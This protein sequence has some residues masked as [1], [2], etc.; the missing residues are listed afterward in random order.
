MWNPLRMLYI[1]K[2]LP[3]G[4]YTKTW[5]DTVHFQSYKNFKHNFCMTKILPIYGDLFKST[6]DYLIRKWTCFRRLRILL[7]FTTYT[8]CWGLNDYFDELLTE[9]Q[10]RG[11]QKPTTTWFPNTPTVNFLTSQ[12]W[13]VKHPYMHWPKISGHTIE[14]CTLCGCVCVCVRVWKRAITIS[15]KRKAFEHV[16]YMSQQ[17]FFSR[18]FFY[19]C[20]KWRE[21]NVMVILNG[22]WICEKS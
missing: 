11:M 5:A 2:Y 16:T 12:W 3:V 21:K 1:R 8:D 19:P 20:T 18:K 15:Q 9:W 10:T 7:L 4:G 6:S 22:T 14:V 17:L 13:H